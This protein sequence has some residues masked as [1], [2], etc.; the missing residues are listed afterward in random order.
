MHAIKLL[1]ARRQLA[2]FVVTYPEL[3]LPV[4]FDNW[5]TQLSLWLYRPRNRLALRR[6]PGQR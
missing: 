1:M 5:Y 2:E 6:H 3:K 4:T